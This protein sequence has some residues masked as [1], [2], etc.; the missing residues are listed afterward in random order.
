[1]FVDQLVGQLLGLSGAQ[2][3]VACAVAVVLPGLLQV[4]VG[5]QRGIDGLTDFGQ[6][7][8]QQF[9]VAEVA[10]RGRLRRQ[11]HG[12]DV[13]DVDVEIGQ[14]VADAFEQR[15]GVLSGEPLLQGMQGGIQ[16]QAGLGGGGGG[17]PFFGLL[18]IGGLVTVPVGFPF[19]D[20]AIG[21]LVEVGQ[22]LQQL[23]R[24]LLHAFQGLAIS[25][26]FLQ[27]GLQR[28]LE[29]LAGLL[30]RVDAVGG[31]QARHDDLVEG[32]L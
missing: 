24:A 22:A 11:G 27:Q 18:G 17:K 5:F 15:R 30:Q 23:F 9:A 21:L 25:L 28:L 8:A 4:S 10:V 6:A 19:H 31:D 26:V 16:G 12:G 20:D 2:Q 13:F 14:M 29:G 7:L 3:Q 1:M 32:G